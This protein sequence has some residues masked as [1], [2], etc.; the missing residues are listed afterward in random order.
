MIPCA[1][2]RSDPLSCCVPN[3]VSRI[4]AQMRVLPYDTRFRM[5]FSSINN[6]GAYAEC[7]FSHFNGIHPPEV[8]YRD[9]IV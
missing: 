5:R 6:A 3:S 9:D 4:T 8:K 2:A 1:Y 7:L